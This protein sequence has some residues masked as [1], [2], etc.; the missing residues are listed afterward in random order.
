MNDDSNNS[1]EEDDRADE[2]GLGSD[3]EG[4]A[5]NSKRRAGRE[6]WEPHPGS[7]PG[8]TPGNYTLWRKAISDHVLS[9]FAKCQKGKQ[10]LG[11]HGAMLLIRPKAKKDKHAT[12][13]VFSTAGTF[14]EFLEL[15]YLQL[16]QI[17]MRQEAHIGIDLE[18][19]ESRLSSGDGRVSI[20]QTATRLKAIGVEEVDIDR[21]TDK[22]GANVASGCDGGAE[23]RRLV[24]CLE[25]GMR[26]FVGGGCQAEESNSPMDDVDEGDGA[27]LAEEKGK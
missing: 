3:E 14:D 8:A 22:F 17:E 26:H 16:E 6:T 10:A 27:G 4:T 20:V 9:M 13:L 5:S 1:E 23:H 24:R 15:A 12:Q 7:L 11:V 18:A 19:I 25:Y 21:C 2:E